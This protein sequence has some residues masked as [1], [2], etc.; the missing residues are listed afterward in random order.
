MKLSSDMVFF[1]RSS[2][3]YVALPF[4]FKHDNVQ[5]ISK[6]IKEAGRQPP[7]LTANTFMLHR[8]L[9]PPIF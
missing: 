7:S 4:R 5:A 9:L 8:I 1:I 6:K 3:H 2:K